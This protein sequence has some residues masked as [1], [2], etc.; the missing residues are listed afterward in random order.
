VSRFPRHEST[1]TKERERRIESTY[2][3]DAGDRSAP[4]SSHQRNHDWMSL[5]RYNPD[6]MEFKHLTTNISYKIEPNPAGGFIARGTDPS[7]AP[8]EAPTMEEVQK[9]IQTQLLGSIAT[10]LPSLSLPMLLAK[11]A[12]ASSKTISRTVINTSDGQS[13]VSKEASPEDMKQFSTKFASILRK[14]FPT[15]AQELS[16]RV[17]GT[18]PSESQS[19]IS[20]QASPFGDGLNIYRDAFPQ[21]AANRP[22]LPETNSAWRFI[23]ICALALGLALAF[24]LYA[25]R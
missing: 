16:T 21:N 25:H 24:L 8:I 10:R 11:G 13:V 4:H 2:L 20:P 19:G 17:D 7:I 3:H 6:E 15:L 14:D 22:I 9:K 12:A 1:K 5:S 23:A 18:V